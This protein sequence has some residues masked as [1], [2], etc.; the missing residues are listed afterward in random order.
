M[1]F[2][3]ILAKA[4]SPSMQGKMRQ[5]NLASPGYFHVPGDTCYHFR[6]WFEQCGPGKEAWACGNAVIGTGDLP[7]CSHCDALAKASFVQHLQSRYPTGIRFYPPAKDLDVENRVKK[8]AA[9]AGKSV[10]AWLYEAACEK[11]ARDR[12]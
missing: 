12:T 1:D 8:A 11:I 10:S 4:V 3:N 9:K 7:P 6:H 5:E 2:R